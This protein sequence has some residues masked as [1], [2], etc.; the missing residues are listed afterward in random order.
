MA[1][2]HVEEDDDKAK[3]VTGQVGAAE[4]S[5]ESPRAMLPPRN[6]PRHKT[7]DRFGCWLMRLRSKVTVTVQ[8]GRL[9][10]PFRFYQVV[11]KQSKGTDK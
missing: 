3:A 7:L 8:C 1:A 10:T 6:L 2:V 5:G 9:Q 11:R 4:E